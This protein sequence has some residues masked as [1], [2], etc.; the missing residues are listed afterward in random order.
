VVVPVYVL[1]YTYSIRKQKYKILQENIR[2]Y[3]K[4]QERLQENTI[5]SIQ[6]RL[7]ES[8]REYKKVQESTR[9]YN[10]DT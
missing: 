3:K 8:T 10:Q 4:A 7:Q 2:K 1:L 5:L 9:E 6:E